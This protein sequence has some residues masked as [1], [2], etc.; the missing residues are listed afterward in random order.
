[1]AATSSSIQMSRRPDRPFSLIA[2]RQ[3]VF[4]GNHTLLDQLPI[5]DEKAIPMSPTKRDYAVSADKETYQA[6]LSDNPLPPYEID[7]EFDTS[8]FRTRVGNII[9]VAMIQASFRRS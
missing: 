4:V 7:P 3:P 6:A 9:A 2:E 1:M 8:K 5:G